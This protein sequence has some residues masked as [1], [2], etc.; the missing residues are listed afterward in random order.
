[1]GKDINN[2]IKLQL[3]GLYGTFGKNNINVGDTVEV[4]C[5]AITS[6]KYTEKVS[7]IDGDWLIFEGDSGKIQYW[8]CTKC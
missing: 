3:M 1:M 4:S 8:F 6:Q 7:E 2:P 5:S